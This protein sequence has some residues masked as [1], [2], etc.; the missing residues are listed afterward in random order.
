M[1]AWKLTQQ[2]YRITLYDAG[3]D[4][5]DQPFGLGATQAGCDARHVTLTE[6]TPW[7][8]PE[9]IN[10]LNTPTAHRGWDG[11]AGKPPER[12]DRWLDEFTKIASAERAH[13][14]N[15][16][17]VVEA[18]RQ[19]LLLWDELATTEP[20][21]FGDC[22]V[23]VSRTMPILFTSSDVA[24]EEYDFEHHFDERVRW[25]TEADLRSTTNMMLPLSMSGFRVPGI[26]FRAKTLCTRLIRQ[27]AVLVPFHWNTRLH[28][29][30]HELIP[31]EC[32]A[33]IWATP[34]APG[35]GTGFDD[36]AL[37]GVA[38]VWLERSWDG[39]STAAF[40]LLGPEPVNYI[41]VTIASGRIMASGGYAYVENSDTASAEN[42]IRILQ[43][44]LRDQLEDQT[45]GVDWSDADPHVCIRPS[46]PSGI[47]ISTADVLDDR[48]VLR[49]GANSA[50][51]FT[52]APLIA[53]WVVAALKS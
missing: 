31:P 46:T 49:I 35:I 2:G 26:A 8:S 5:A 47:G 30:D 28:P 10:L 20:Q 22:A 6:T 38:G 25:M 48:R 21:L 50:G 1:T 15:T 43:D 27:L 7:T 24:Q 34:W 41:N 45:V 33:V 13:R 18:N 32:S 11:R 51:G 17:E 40:K 53:N 44:Q 4:P 12:S 36:L 9:R 23:G 39:P 19:G 14:E 3:P 52:Q 42:T 16:A 37:G 29:D